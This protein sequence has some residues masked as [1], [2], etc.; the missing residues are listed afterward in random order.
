MWR[1]RAQS[2]ERLSA[3]RKSHATADVP[4]VN[5]TLDLDLL[6]QA[7][8]RVVS[9]R[10]LLMIGVTDKEIRWRLR[11]DGPWQVMLP[12]VYATFTGDVAKRHWW[13]G[14]LLYAREGA[15]LTGEPALELWGVTSQRNPRVPVLVPHDRHR[16]SR[17]QV[18]IVRTDRPP[19]T[20][21]IDGL[22]TAEP[23]R[24]VVDAC[25]IAIDLDRVRDL[26]TVGLRSPLIDV[27]AVE[28]EVAAGPRRGSARLRMVL[29]E[30]GDGVRSVAEAKAR[31]RILQLRLPKPGFNVDLYTRGGAFVA[32]PD[33]YWPEAGLAVEVDSRRH[34]SD[35]KDWER[36]QRRHA[37]MT[38]CGLVVIHASPHRI[39]TD[40]ARLA[41]EIVAAYKIAVARPPAEVIVGA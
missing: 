16:A 35:T 31:E 8:H 29:A 22:L 19:D 3:L 7:Q 34:H 25:R 28:D 2:T 21:V 12:G 17:K 36:T 39:L 41:A 13:H 33:A 18:S 1:A 30:Y 15:A 20:K 24:A 4:Y 32:R 6:V 5:R 23:V 10:Q 37:R 14:G 40:W 9:R 26:I 38:A 27:T 11:P